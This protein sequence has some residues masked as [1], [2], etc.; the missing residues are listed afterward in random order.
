MKF[1]SISITN[2]SLTEFFQKIILKDGPYVTNLHDNQSKG[3]NL[4][5]FFI[6]RNTAVYFDSLGIYHVPQK[7]LSKIEDK[8][9][10]YNIFRKQ[11]DDSIMYGFYCIV[12][13]T[14]MLE[15]NFR[16]T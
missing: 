12:F 14:Y 10:T 6:D 11:S 16:L 2:L 7:V 8:S 1:L 5:L 13:I 15:G 3:T 4:F 9:I